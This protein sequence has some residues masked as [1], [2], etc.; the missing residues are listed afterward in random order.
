ME[1]TIK[2]AIRG[3]A[4]HYY[5]FSH[6]ENEFLEAEMNKT[7]LNTRDTCHEYDGASCKIYSVLYTC[8]THIVKNR[9]SLIYD[10]ILFFINE[11]ELKILARIAIE[12]Y[13]KELIELL[14]KEGEDYNFWIRFSNH[15]IL[16][17]GYM[18]HGLEI[19]KF[20]GE[21]DNNI[22]VEAGFAEHAV[23]N[24]DT[25]FLEYLIESGRPAND[26]FESV[27]YT[28]DTKKVLD[29]FMD[30]IDITKFEGL[31]LD[32]VCIRAPHMLMLLPE[33]G[34][35]IDA[36][37]KLLDRACQSKNVEIVEFCLQRGMQVSKDI[38]D[39]FLYLGYCLHCTNVQINE[40][41]KKILNL[42]IRYN[43]DFSILKLDEPI[44]YELI[45]N[46]ENLGLNKD[47]LLLR[48]LNME[49]NVEDLSHLITNLFE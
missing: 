28:C 9:L 27:F 8:Y 25:Q 42:F 35:S 18:N 21:L 22:K 31:I 11:D 14:H 16:D 39:K 49:D 17:R 5:Y 41:K 3:S 40:N 24:N 30:K 32:Y 47:A 38:L 12:E 37:I 29:L 2:D 33:Y 13:N 4:L 20:L 10:I 19:I 46:L 36:N 23:D 43:V 44:D 7:C 1:S 45:T 15:H 26:I 48:L 34:I 6:P